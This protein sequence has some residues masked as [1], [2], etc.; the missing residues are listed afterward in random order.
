M[1]DFTKEQL[2]QGVDNAIAAGDLA[3]AQALLAR[4]NAVSPVPTTSL[5]EQGVTGANVGVTRG[6]GA[7][8]DIINAGLSKIGFGSDYPIGGS[9][10]LQDLFQTISA[11]NAIS[12]VPP[13]TSAQKIL[14]RTT[15]EVG[16]AVP[17]ALGAAATVPARAV[18]AAPTV[19]NAARSIADDV[20]NAY[21]AS[22]AKFASAEAAAAA[23]G[24]AAAGATSLA[25]PDN[26]TAEVV[27]QIVGGLGGSLAGNTIERLATKL[28]KGPQTP[29]ALKSAAGDLYDDVRQ[30]N[31]AFPSTTFG[32]VAQSARDI[33]KDQGILLPNGKL[34]PD[35]TKVQGVLNILDLY[36]KSNLIDPAQV[37]ATRQGIASRA[38]DASGTSEGVILRRILKEFDD[39]TSQLAPQIRVANSMYQ[40]AMK[41]ETLTDL[42]EIA[43]VNAGQFSQSGMENAVRG[44]FRDLSRRIIRGQEVG[45]TPEEVTAINQIAAGGT[46]DNA[47]R[48]VGKFAPR[49]PVSMGTGMGTVGAGLMA[50][51]RD[52]YVAAAGAGAFGGTALGANVA[53]GALQTRAV[54]DL[55]QKVI[56]GRPL[57]DQGK[58]RMRAALMAYM[59]GAGAQQVAQ[60]SDEQNQR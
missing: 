18:T 60:P 58:E 34:D 44:Q 56:A 51:T 20:R 47:L 19:M 13:Q 43:K 46:I 25:F 57:S 29:E 6:L 49:G 16:A 12:D 28:P 24:G 36:K 59:A 54:E 4:A 15:E 27:A 10:S 40:R 41:G 26:A 33:A 14:R 53:A 1:A 22:P 7:P 52:P 21:R 48:F 17:M 42:L 3:A 23:G 35:Y 39:E 8:V 9:Q 55:I 37:L 30:A 5:L 31:M 45:W 32:N 2:L 11:G 38:R 50:I